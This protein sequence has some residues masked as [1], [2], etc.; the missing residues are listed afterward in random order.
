MV[1]LPF[2]LMQ[3]S[4]FLSTAIPRLCNAST[5]ADRS[6]NQHAALAA[7]SR[8]LIANGNSCTALKIMGAGTC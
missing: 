1:V 4:F 2:K 7:M 3:S 8:L 6:S 5:L